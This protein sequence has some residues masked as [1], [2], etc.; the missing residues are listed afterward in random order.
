[1]WPRNYT[2][3]TQG[4][5]GWRG[6]LEHEEEKL[7]TSVAIMQSQRSKGSTVV[8]TNIRQDNF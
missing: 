8:G 3:R 4:N 5:V 1:M 7:E 6:E 2:H